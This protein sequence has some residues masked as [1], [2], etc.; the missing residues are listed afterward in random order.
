MTSRIRALELTNIY[1]FDAYALNLSAGITIIRGANATGKTSIL[2]AIWLMSTGRSFRAKPRDMVRHGTDNA[3]INAVVDCVPSQAMA[4]TTTA[5][6]TMSHALDWRYYQ[7]ES[8]YRVDGSVAATRAEH[9]RILPVLLMLP[10]DLLFLN[11]LPKLRRTRL[12][13]GVFYQEPSYAATLSRYRRA[14]AQRNSALRQGWQ[15]VG[16]WDDALVEE[17]LRIQAWCADYCAKW[18]ATLKTVCATLLPHIQHMEL[19]Y[20]FAITS[21]ADYK[22]ALSDAL[23]RDRKQG[24]TSIGPHRA[25]IS[26]LANGRALAPQLSRG[27][28]RLFGYAVYIAQA[29]LQRERPVLLLDDFS[30]EID[31]NNRARLLAMLDDVGGQTIISSVEGTYEGAAD[32]TVDAVVELGETR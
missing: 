31:R 26:A 5:D 10:E 12:D 14:L 27:E 23:V 2:D 25:D 32:S 4:V 21:A 28:A 8:Q 1:L 15:D 22:N 20:T 24:V 17:G 29:L 11:A 16:V 30:S 19:G 7:G 9:A 13:W 18:Q 3:H 6:K